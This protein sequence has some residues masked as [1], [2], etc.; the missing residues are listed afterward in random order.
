M[1]GGAL[2]ALIMSTLAG[3]STAIGGLI[4]VL[5]RRTD[6]K[7]MSFSLGFSAGVMVLISF[8][9]LLP[10][11][12]GSL[13]PA[14]GARY[15]GAAAAVSV[16]AGMFLALLIDRLVPSGPV[17]SGS[18]P[19]AVTAR[20]SDVLWRVGMVTAIA[21]MVHNLPEGIA[22]FMAGYADTKVGVPVAVSIALH[23]IPEGIS[24]AVPVYF[25]TGSRW[26]AFGWSTL[27][28]LSEPAGALL[29]FLVLGPFLSPAM[30]GVIFGAVAGIML[31]ISFDGLIP[32][33]QQS[34]HTPAA[35]GGIFS[36]VVFMEIALTAFGI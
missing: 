35:V 7:F 23:N 13:I 12:R 26:K 2:S 32:A 14:L 4:A 6:E 25:G 11:A 24:V 19:K 34:G 9:E 27:S 20:H 1:N 18:E 3:M 33:S 30:L 29:A 10:D 8:R 16:A 22:T 5:S 31:A 21:V 17:P 15:A 28:G 36:G